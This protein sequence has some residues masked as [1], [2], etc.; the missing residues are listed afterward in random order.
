MTI[1]QAVEQDVEAISVLLG[2]V[3]AYYGGDHEPADE[4]QVHVA[5][6]AEPP[7]A[8]V[9]LAVDGTAVVGLASFSRLWPAAGADTSMYLKELFV[10]EPARRRGIGAQLLDAVKEAAVEAGCSRLE[11]TGD[12][13]NPTALTF[14]KKLGAPIHQTKTFYRLPL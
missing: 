3:E 7:A 8:T 6:F 14:Y 12:T 9:L 1:R 10:A 13:D 2:E 5:L 4:T 11:W